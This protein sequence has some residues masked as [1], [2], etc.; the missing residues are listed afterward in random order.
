MGS[1]GLSIWKALAPQKGAG[2][3]TLSLGGSSSFQASS[4]MSVVVSP[5]VIHYT[6]QICE[7]LSKTILSPGHPG[8]LFVLKFA[9]IPTG[10]FGMMCMQKQYAG[11]CNSVLRVWKHS[12][13]I[14]NWNCIWHELFLWTHV[15][16]LKLGKVCFIYKLL[17]LS[18]TARWPSQTIFG[19]ST[20]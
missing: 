17:G 7:A 4:C 3:G 6:A 8:L 14:L 12:R 16:E 15:F 10:P 5:W 1:Y 2:P 19:N 9:Q 13:W 18:P 20:H 11:E